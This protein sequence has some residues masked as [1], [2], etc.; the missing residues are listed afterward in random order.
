[1]SLNNCMISK[2]KYED[3]KAYWDHQ[4]FLEYNRE[5][6]WVDAEHFA[7]EEDSA[8]SIFEILWNKIDYKDMETPPKNWVPK[9]IELRLEGE[10]YS[11][12]PIKGFNTS[13]I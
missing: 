11:Y 7:D 2:E 10:I 9:N 13:Q 5:K 12:K 6:V 1:M 3:L 4:R 8:E